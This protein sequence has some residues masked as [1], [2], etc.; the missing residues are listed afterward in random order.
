MKIQ[1]ASDLH[2]EMRRSHQPEIH[3]FD[4]VEDRHG[5]N[6]TSAQSAGR[7]RRTTVTCGSLP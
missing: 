2:L 5:C 4:P 1:I 6:D 3:D 7:T